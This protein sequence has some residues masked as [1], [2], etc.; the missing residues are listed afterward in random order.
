MANIEQLKLEL[1]QKAIDTY[2]DIIP[3]KK[4]F[5]EYNG[6]LYF[7]FNVAESFGDT[8]KVMSIDL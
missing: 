7:W 8:T 6:K 1:Q 3:L 4:C 5:S 2:G